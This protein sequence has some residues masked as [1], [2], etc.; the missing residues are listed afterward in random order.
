[1]AELRGEDYMNKMAGYVERNLKKGF[2][3]DQLENALMQQGHSR[4]ATRR[5]IKIATERMPKTE[6]SAEPM[7]QSQVVEEEKKEL[8]PLK[9]VPGL[10]YIFGFVSGIIVFLNAKK[11]DKFMRFHGLQAVFFSIFAS[12]IYGIIYGIMILI[13]SIGG[14]SWGKWA[15]MFSLIF[16]G[17]F[18]LWMLKKMF[19]AFRGIKKRM[20]VVGYLSENLS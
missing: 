10:A 18:E 2:S 12:I 16:W 19:E 8:P 6:I 5:A 1:M 20:P 15:P 7:P 17:L 13:D 9:V 4:V 14:S 3:V 11:E